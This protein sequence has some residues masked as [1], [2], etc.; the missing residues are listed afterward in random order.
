M[1]ERGDGR[2]V[3]LTGA[4]GGV[5]VL[6]A[7]ALAERGLRVYAGTHR[8][9]PALDAIRGV[10]PFTLDVTDAA[11][12]ADALA[13]V[14]ADGCDRL[15]GVV[16]NAGVIV[17]GPLELVPEA[18]LQRQ[19]DVNV[20]GAA[21]VTRAFLPLLRAGSGRL[22][23]VTAISA[24]MPGPFFGPIA[25][26]KA[27]LAS[28]S[29]ALRLELAPWGI[30]VVE[31]EPGGAATE[32]FAKAASAAE[33]SSAALPAEQVALYERQLAAFAAASAAMRLS[34]PT[35]IADAIV[36]ALT[37]A[38]PKPRYTVGRDARAMAL[39]A[40]LPIR[41]RDRVVSRAVGLSKA[42]A[43]R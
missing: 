11:S 12:V 24:R 41:A 36:K 14:Q 43:A 20:L 38:R 28:I 10:R 4:G 30:D 6:A 7:R 16:N 21:R 13:R 2:A 32:I 25:A 29:G 8:E 1:A 17:Q 42:P 18:E 34:S 3:L 39:I 23:N 15:A 31:I 22:V 5:G 9:A 40:R 27:A 19:F 26:S 35:I 37:V 33:R